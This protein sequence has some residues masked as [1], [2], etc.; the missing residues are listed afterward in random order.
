MSVTG[1]NQ[2][3]TA[4][5]PTG[6]FKLAWG[7]YGYARY[8]QSYYGQSGSIT[9]QSKSTFGAIAVAIGTPIGLLLTLTYAA[10]FTVGSGV[11]NQS[12]S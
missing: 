11:T 7:G 10:A 2:T 8:N 1:T 12:K 9:N 5:S 6:Q 4:V 3:K